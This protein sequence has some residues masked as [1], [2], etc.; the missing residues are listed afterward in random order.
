MN[1]NFSIYVYV[2]DKDQFERPRTGL[3]D[4]VNTGLMEKVLGLREESNWLRIVF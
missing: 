4:N 1:K 2:L 3:K